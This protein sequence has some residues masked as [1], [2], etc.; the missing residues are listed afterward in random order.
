MTT[1]HFGPDRIRADYPPQFRSSP[2][3]LLNPVSPQATSDY[4][5]PLGS[6][7]LRLAVP[8]LTRPL[9]DYPCPVIPPRPLPPGSGQLIPLQP[10]HSFRPTPASD[11][12]SLISAPQLN[13]QPARPS[14]ASDDPVL[15][16]SARFTLTTLFSSSHIDPSA[17]PFPHRTDWSTRFDSGRTRLARTNQVNS[18]RLAPSSQLPPPQRNLD[19]DHNQS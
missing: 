16:S 1:D 5:R 11:A 15:V 6:R 13:D 2:Y 14:P 18:P 8:L 17:R 19:E 7:P 10:D 12:P 4:P 3:R 9:P